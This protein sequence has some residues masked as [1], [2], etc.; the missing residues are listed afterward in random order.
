MQKLARGAIAVAAVCLL[1]TP[2]AAQDAQKGK[3]VAEQ[4][5]CTGCHGENLGGDRIG[6][7]LA[8]NIT[9]DKL[10][11]VGAWS[12]DELYSYLRSGVAKGRAHAGGLMAG[13]VDQMAD[14]PDAD[15]RSLAAWLRMTQPVH[16]AANRT[17]AS[18]FGKPVNVDVAVRG[19]LKNGA[20]DGAH[21]FSGAC[22]SCHGHDGA[23]SPDG[24]YPS[25]FR[26]S[27]VG[28]ADPTNL[29]ATILFGVQRK[30]GKP[31]YM[32]A[33]DTSTG[34][35]MVLSDPEIAAIATFVR[36]TYGDPASKP[37]FAADVK[38]VRDAQ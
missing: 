34:V 3:A 11:G 22:A 6:A 28:R 33:F 4:F 12:N 31:A 36:Q 29:I 17:P 1:M 16:D 25:L 15:I 8:P 5:N 37:V 14:T 7:W 30:T 24:S 35:G 20:P 32:P 23:G 19:A 27:D 2:V 26:N 9:S 13:V 10:S 18:E 38:A 21:L